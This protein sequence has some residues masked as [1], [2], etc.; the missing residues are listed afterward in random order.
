MSTGN[1][2]VGNAGLA[3]GAVAAWALALLA[4]GSSGCSQILGIEELNEDRGDPV[5][6]SPEIPSE[7]FVD[8]ALGTE[9]DTCSRTQ[10]CK[11]LTQA[12]AQATAGQTIYLGSGTYGR[13]TEAMNLTVPAGVTIE[14]MTPGGALLLGN[15]PEGA[16]ALTLQGDATLRG[17]HISGFYAGIAALEGEVTLDSLAIEQTQVGLLL[18]GPV[19]MVAQ[20][21]SFTAGGQAFQMGSAAE[22]RLVGGTISDMGP[23]CAGGVGIGYLQESAHVIF[24]GVTAQNNFGSLELRQASSADINDSTLSNNGT[25]G[26]GRST[27]IDLG[28]SASLRMMNT[29]VEQG[30]GSGVLALSDNQVTIMGGSFLGNEQLEALDVNASYLDVRG[31]KFS[32]YFT[33]VRIGR[34]SNVFRDVTINGNLVGID[35]NSDENGILDLGSAEAP[36]N[37]TIQQ[38]ANVGLLVRGSAPAVIN[39]VGNTW[40]PGE[41]GADVNGKMPP[42]TTLTGPVTGSNV[43]ISLQGPS[44]QF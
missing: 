16:T 17:L 20:S 30:P 35:W 21:V 32:G 23:N 7:L 22:L 44:I 40:I 2:A 36:G 3:R 42:G 19:Q 13:D 38:N 26:C 11:T 34:G 10:P 43:E 18:Q 39:A 27:H 9:Q 31:T 41:Q 15:R 24:E 14:A 4:A 8:P 6:A 28:E 12:L 25:D 37:N 1:H 29:T 33:A 5:D